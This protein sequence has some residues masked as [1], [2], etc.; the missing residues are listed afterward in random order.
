MEIDNVTVHA[1]CARARAVTLGSADKELYEASRG[2]ASLV[3]H[4]DFMLELGYPQGEASELGCDASAVVAIA[5]SRA[6][7]KSSLFLARRADFLQKLADHVRVVKIDG[8]EIRAD[9]LTKVVSTAV[10]ARLRHI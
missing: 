3:A 4:R 9:I 2:C 8:A 7:F 5:S 6:S 10:F 1:Q